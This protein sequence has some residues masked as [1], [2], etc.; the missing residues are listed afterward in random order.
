MSSARYINISSHRIKPLH[1]IVIYD[2]ML[3]EMTIIAGGSSNMCTAPSR[4]WKLYIIIRC[5]IFTPF[6]THNNV[7]R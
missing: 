7:Y 2:I 5:I 1:I 4:L 3:I 6:K